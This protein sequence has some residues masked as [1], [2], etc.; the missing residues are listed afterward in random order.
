VVARYEFRSAA[1]GVSALV[2]IELYWQSSTGQGAGEKSIS[3]WAYFSLRRP[4]ALCQPGDLVYCDPPY[5]FSQAI[6]YGA[7][8]FSFEDL[9]NR[10]EGCKKRGVFVALSIDGSKKSGDFLCDLKVPKDFSLE[11]ETEIKPQENHALEGLYKTGEIFS[12][13]TA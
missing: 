12:T 1:G 2:A 4:M 11:I 8:N 3:K 10:I 5:S 7:Q 13:P 9:L 6:L